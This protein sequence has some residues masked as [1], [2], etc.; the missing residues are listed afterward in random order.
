MKQ[1]AIQKK[2]QCKY[3]NNAIRKSGKDKF[4]VEL[5]VKCKLTELNDL[6][7]K[8]INDYNSLYP[9]GYN[10]TKGGKTTRSI[11]IKNNDILNEKSK[12]GRDYGYNHKESTKKLMSARLKKI[13]SEQNREDKMRNVMNEHYDL[14]KIEILSNYDLSGDYDDYIKQEKLPSY[15]R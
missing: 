12:R 15:L 2:N 7:I 10:L 6:E 1:F 11:S 5:I 9:N 14:K 13:S 3:L 4:S 8:Y